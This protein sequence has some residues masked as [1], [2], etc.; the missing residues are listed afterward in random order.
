M[1]VLLAGGGTAGHIN[2]ALAIAGKLLSEKPDTQIAFV[3][4]PNG[5]ENRLVPAAGFPLY[6][7]KVMGLQR[8]LTPKNFKA[9]YY[10]LKSPL[11]A[12]KIIKEFKPDLVIGTGG[13][14]SW[15]VL[16]A[17]AKMHVPTAIH[18][19]NALPGLTTKM[20]SKKVD[21]VFLSFAES[22]KYFDCPVDK[23]VLTGNPLRGELY[24]V[25]RKTE[26]SRL[27]LGEK[28][29]YVL[30][31]GGS[32]GAR[33]LNET[34][35]RFE[36]SLTEEDNVTVCHALGKTSYAK[37]VE[38]NTVENLG[39]SDKKFVQ[40]LEYID[41]MPARMAAADLVICR[42][43]ALTLSEL[44][45]LKKPAI[46]VPSPYVADDHQ[47]KNA[48]VFRDGKAAELVT[49]DELA[50]DR[51]LEVARALLEDKT[52]L[53]VMSRAMEHFAVG[54]ASDR[55]YHSLMALV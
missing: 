27:G 40:I 24:R 48:A 29:R 45:F 25:N 19:Q 23:L 54:D 41:D 3:G 11:D 6:H 22:E 47:F 52:R 5:L 10:A 51:L 12:K 9:L 49:E 43:G 34:L 21:L 17:A 53:K 37:A 32:L 26:R 28:D 15:P 31:F 14:V 16:S 44:A 1:K 42:A 4:T 46:L 30:A 13:Y 20:L 39:L 2:P 38:E 8:R 33:R 36:Q 35:F 50:G 7:V 55:I 18:E